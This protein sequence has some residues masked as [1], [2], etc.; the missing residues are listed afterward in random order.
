MIAWGM[1]V[2]SAWAQEIGTSSGTPYYVELHNGERVYA[3]KI[4]YRSPVFKQNF[5][6]LDDS[7]KYAPESVKYFYNQ[8]GFFAR[9]N[10]G[11]RY[12]DFAQRERAGKVSTYFVLR[13]EYNS[14]G[15][16][17]GMGMGGV[18]VGMG[19]GYGYPS[20]R[21]VYY[22][23]KDDGPL[24]PMNYRNLRTA[25]ADNPGSLESLQQYKRGQNIQTAAY[26][27]GAGLIFAGLQQQFKGNGGGTSPLLFV[28]LGVTLLPTL[29]N[30]GKKDRLT[31]AIEVYNFTP[32]N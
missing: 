18:G 11:R 17:F 21:R 30:F 29:I 6:Q 31:E 7:L 8:D 9:L 2:S 12:S 26:V 3:S 15:P 27:L 28:G 23:S 32:S 5:F 1:A 13:T 20:Q 16:G 19:G 14:M 22:F 4:Q 25:L 24:E 10:A